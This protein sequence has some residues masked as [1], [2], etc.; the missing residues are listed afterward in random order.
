MTSEQQSYYELRQPPSDGISSVNF[1]PYSVNL[2]VTSWDNTVRCY[3][4]QNNV[5]KWQ[6]THKGPVLDGC[7]P[8]KTKI[9]SSDIFGGI[10]QYDPVSGVE[11]EIGTHKKGVKSIV[12]NI[13][14]QQLY[15]GSWDQHLK[16]WDTRSDTPEISSHNLESKVYTMDCSS[17]SNMLVVGTADKYITIFDIRKMDM[18]LQKRESSIKY[19]TRCIRCFTDGK[20]YALA[21]VEGRIAMEYFDPS[22]AAQSKKY[23]FKC[24]RP[25]EGGVDVVYP[26]NC[27]AFNPI[28]GTFATGGCDKNVFFWD[29]ANRKRLHFLKTYPTSI[30]SMSFNSDG[31]IL[32]VASSYTFE[33]GEKDH[34]PDQIFIHHINENKIKPF[35]KPPQ[36]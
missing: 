16:V 28:Y 17:I 19:Q 21:S 7:F 15:S 20:G 27:I 10:K 29:G 8:E 4:T 26:V 11:K 32:A 25:N 1:C 31:N 33:E 34:P 12:Y 13:T 23:A 2:L 30:S 9:Y 5:Q 36:K 24:H 22:P 6:Y 3:D 35:E 14:T 18:P